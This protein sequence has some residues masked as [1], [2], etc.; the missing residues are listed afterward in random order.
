M[1]NLQRGQ[2]Y[3]FIYY[4]KTCNAFHFR[5]KKYGITRTFLNLRS[6]LNFFDYVDTIYNLSKKIYDFVPTSAMRDIW[7]ENYNVPCGSCGKFLWSKNVWKVHVKN[8]DGNPRGK[9]EQAL[10]KSRIVY[11]Q[12]S[13]IKK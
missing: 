5:L 6:A 7:L 10:K 8:C 3:Y 9:D 1:K 2:I 11:N 4:S 13:L 12:F